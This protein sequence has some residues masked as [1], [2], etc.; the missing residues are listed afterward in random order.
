MRC[1]VDVSMMRTLLLP[2]T[3]ETASRDASSGRHRMAMSASFRRSSRIVALRRSASGME[4]SS[5]SLRPAM[6]VRIC[7]PVVPC[8]PSMKI[9]GFMIFPFFQKVTSHCG[10]NLTQI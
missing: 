6:R 1:A 2:E 3:I 10:I 8:S 7:N 9:F 5:R 4:S